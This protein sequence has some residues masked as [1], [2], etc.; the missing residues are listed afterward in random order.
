[1]STPRHALVIGANRGI[2]LELARLLLARGQRVS[3]SYRSDAGGLHALVGATL[4]EGIDLERTE[5]LAPLADGER[6]DDLIVNA[7]IYPQDKPNDRPNAGPGAIDLSALMRGFAVNAAGPLLAVQALGKRLGEGSRVLL[8]T[9]RMGSIADN[10]SGHSYAYR[11]SKAALNMAGKTLSIDLK[12]RGISVALIH[13]GWVRTDM[14]SGQGLLDPNESAAGIL[15]RL[16]DL[17]LAKTGTF[18]HQNGQ[19]LPW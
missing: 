13:P 14:T 1:M 10:D 5:T 9:S 2:G 3:A 8:V 19:V 15:A 18:W 17:D 7:G 16:D 12:P 11:M 4:I 6:V